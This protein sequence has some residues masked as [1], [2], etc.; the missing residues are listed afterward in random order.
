MRDITDFGQR[1]KL[2][3]YGDYAFLVFYGAGE[4]SPGAQILCARC[5]CSSPATT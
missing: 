1:P 4:A 2:D 3:N 5:T